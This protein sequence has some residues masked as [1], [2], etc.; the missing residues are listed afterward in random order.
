MPARILSCS[1]LDP[2]L[3]WVRIKIKALRKIIRE[4]VSLTTVDRLE[5]LQDELDNALVNGSITKLDYDQQWT[6]ILSAFGWDEQ[7]YAEEIDRRWDYV[8]KSTDV[9]MSP[10]NYGSN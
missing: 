10:R 9:Y 8:D 5:S 2:I 3:I 7:K 6:E 4:V 1:M